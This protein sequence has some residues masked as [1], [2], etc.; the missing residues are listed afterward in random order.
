MED[1]IVLDRKSFEALAAES[2]VRI[3]KALKQRRKTLSEI[4]KELEMSVSGTKEHLQN[5]EDAGLIQKMDDGHKWKYYELTKKGKGV[6]GPKEL[7]VWI[8]LSL[9]TVALVVS[10]FSLLSLDGGGQPAAMTMDEALVEG[11]ELTADAGGEREAGAMY[12]LPHEDKNEVQEAPDGSEEAPAEQELPVVPLLVA[13]IS[14]VCVL[15]SV[16]ILVRNRTG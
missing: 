11:P 4:S 15:G 2:R 7:K 8:L 13:V 5:L 12:A 1:K 10:M 3:L 9:S 14:A 16:A 6:V